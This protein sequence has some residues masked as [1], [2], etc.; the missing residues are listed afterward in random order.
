MFD[1]IKEDI[2]AASSQDPA[3]RNSLEILFTYPGVHAMWWYRRSHW[4]WKHNRHQLGRFVSNM[5]RFFTGIE[6]HPG[7]EIGKRFFIDHGMGVV[8]GETTIIGDDVLLYQGAVLGGTSLSK[9]KR[10]PTIGNG[11]VVGAGA[12]VLGDIKIGDNAK[13]GAGSVVLEDIP[14]GATCVGIPGRVVKLNGTSTKLDHNKLPDPIAEMID[15]ILK[16]QLEIETKIQ[17]LEGKHNTPKCI[18][19]SNPDLGNVFY[20]DTSE[21]DPNNIIFKNKETESGVYGEIFGQQASSV[22]NNEEKQTLTDLIENLTEKQIALEK[23]IE[24]LKNKSGEKR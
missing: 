5:G 19:D 18:I 4:L 10:H 11:V 20:K 17:E 3:A 13:V 22:L 8:I 12:K 21:I 14:E 15:I 16:R 7:A 9:G 24:E 6:I 2:E 23:E 1:A